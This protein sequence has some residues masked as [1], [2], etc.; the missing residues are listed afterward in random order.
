MTYRWIRYL[1][2]LFLGILLYPLGSA[3]GTTPTILVLGDSLSAAYGMAPDAG[4]VKRLQQRIAK[5]GYP[6]QVVNASISG[7]TTRAGLT[8]LPALLAR[9]HPAIVIVELGGNDGL[10]G[11]PLAEI[12]HNLSAIIEKSRATGAQVLLAGIRLPPNYGPAYTKQFHEI[13]SSLAQAHGV[14]LVPFLLE[15]VADRSAWMQP[16]GIHPHADG[17]ERML[18]NVWAHLEPLL[19]RPALEK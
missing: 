2:S 10:R 19:E 5:A 12:R 1:Y 7:D 17:Q 18:E 16:D 3:L 15:G 14:G 9:H 8:R 4:W 6:Y 13:Y 11:L